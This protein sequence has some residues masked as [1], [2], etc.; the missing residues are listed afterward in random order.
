MTICHYHSVCLPI[1]YIAENKVRTPAFIYSRDMEKEICLV[2]CIY[3]SIGVM[4]RATDRRLLFL[5]QCDTVQ[6]QLYKQLALWPLHKP[7]KMSP[8]HLLNNFFSLTMPYHNSMKIST[9]LNPN[10]SGRYPAG[11]VLILQLFQKNP[12]SLSLSLLANVWVSNGSES[13]VPE[14]QGENGSPVLV[15][16][17]YF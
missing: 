14:T 10:F 15:F 2:Y 17:N 3:Q 12:E 8:V 7:L 13:S 11:P 6:S 4:F 9:V 16:S 1:N 5:E